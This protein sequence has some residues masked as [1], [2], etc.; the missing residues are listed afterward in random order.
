MFELGRGYGLWIA[1][2]TG[3]GQSDT[4]I[5]KAG[6]PKVEPMLGGMGRADL[7]PPGGARGGVPGSPLIEG[8]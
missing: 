3:S 8:K 1:Q 6:Y 5:T 4:P 2:D 7:G